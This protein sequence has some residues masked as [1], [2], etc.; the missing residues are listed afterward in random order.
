[1]LLKAKSDPKSLQIDDLVRMNTDAVALV[2]HASH[3]LQS[4]Q[5]VNETLVVVQ[6]QYNPPPFPRT[7]LILHCE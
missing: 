4:W 6:K 3:E 1:M 7:M 5:K 2:S